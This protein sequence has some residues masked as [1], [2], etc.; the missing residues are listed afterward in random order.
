MP[1]EDAWHSPSQA[2]NSFNEGIEEVSCLSPWTTVLLPPPRLAGM[3]KTFFKKIRVHLVPIIVLS[4]L[5]LLV[6]AGTLGHDFLM[7]WDDRLYVVENEAIRGMTWGHIKDAFTRFYVGNYAPLQIISYMLDYT[8][9][10]LRPGGFIFTNVLVH[11]VNG[12]LFYMLLFR[13]HRRKALGF[14]AAFIFLLHPVQVESVAWISQRKNLLAL[15]FFLASFHFYLS[16][17]T[18]EKRQRAFFY[19]SSVLAF[20]LALLTKSVAIILPLVLFLYDLCY[21]EKSDRKSWI[22][23]KIPFMLAAG[24]ALLI[25]LQSQMPEHDGGRIS[26]AIEGPLSV[27]YTMLTVLA[28]YFKLLLLPT[29]LSAVYMPPMKIRMDAAVAWSALL[30]TSLIVLGVY[31]Y[32]RRKE[33]FFWYALFFIG[34]LPVSQIVSIVTLMND[35]YLY[36]PMVGAAAFYGLIVFSSAAPASDLRRRSI[37]IALVLFVM[38]IPWISW[39]RTSVWSNDSSL[40]MDTARKTPG[41][42][43]AWNGLGMAYVGAGRSDDAAHAFLKALSIDP[44]YQLALNNIGALY[45]STGRLSEARPFLLRIVELFPDNVNG[46]MNLGINYYLS[47]EFP[48]AEAMFKKV[49]ALQPQSPDALTFLG[50]VYLKMKKL[51]SARSHYSEAAKMGGNTAHLEYGLACV[52]ALSGHRREALERLEAAFQ[53]GYDDYENV[54]KDADLDALRGLV[55]FQILLRKHYG[56]MGGK[57]GLSLRQQRDR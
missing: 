50:D 38:P 7:N 1:G 6:Y 22:A 39:Q 12:I 14:L 32:R 53:L 27:F 47:R 21:I 2:Y 31:L 26:Y 33:L 17:R 16:Y 40:W 56:R 51:E 44:D 25:A 9:W 23:N 24:A 4:G 19:A 46:L 55:D 5:T 36:F 11:A 8:F 3:E 43:L 28:R 18:S 42:P 41:S 45:N 52:E 13:I 57:D 29:E 20:V 10:G 54:T 15:F 49:L 37:A 48:D 35:R 30:A 34:L